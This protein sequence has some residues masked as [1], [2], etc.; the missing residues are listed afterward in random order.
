MCRLERG[1][2]T[3]NPT[4]NPVTT[5][6]LLLIDHSGIEPRGRLDVTVLWK[7]I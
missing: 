7:T 1:C 3:P 6:S 2:S 4:P 5:T